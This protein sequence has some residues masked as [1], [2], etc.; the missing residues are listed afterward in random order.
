MSLS[1]T[2]PSVPS[3]SD[4]ARARAH[5]T[6]DA[7]DL[8]V[9]HEDTKG[10]ISARR[11]FIRSATFQPDRL[12]D[13]II[14]AGLAD[15]AFRGLIELDSEFYLVVSRPG[16]ASNPRFVLGLD[17]LPVDSLDRSGH[18]SGSLK[19]SYRNTSEWD[20]KNLPETLVA[21]GSVVSQDD[22]TDSGYHLFNDVFGEP[23]A[24]LRI[25][26]TR[27]HD[28]IGSR[29]RNLLLI[30]FGGFLLGSGYLI[31]TAI[32]RNVFK[33]IER[34][35]QSLAQIARD[36]QDVQTVP[37]SGSV[38]VGRL[39]TQVNEML[40]RLRQSESHL[41]RTERM[42]VAGE[43]SAGV[44]HNL[45]NILTGILGPAEFLEQ[46]LEDPVHLA[47]ARRIY[48]ASIRARDLVSRFGQAV[49]HGAPL[50]SRAVEVNDTVRTAIEA[51]RPRWQDESQREGVQI[52]IE[53][54]LRATLP[55][56]GTPDELHDII[57]SLVLNA[58]DALP[59]GGTVRIT[60]EE[61]SGNV[62]LRVSDDGIGMND[63][64]I[65]RV[66]EPFFT[67]KASIGSG[68]GLAAVHG[69]ATRWG[70]P[71]T[72]QVPSAV[73]PNSQ[74]NSQDRGKT[75]QVF[76]PGPYLPNPRIAGAES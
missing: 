7:V 31:T 54:D 73:D 29:T 12:I 38:D 32:R 2:H 56:Q 21:G 55:I 60:T 69:V 25:D 61:A 47:E 51:S 41:I 6:N 23:A 4:P 59:E 45:N 10:V 63:E 48:R 16:N 27:N 44:S 62:I 8:S 75:F 11:S 13:R 14:V 18:S 70:A 52:A 76:L 28:T 5:K 20:S 74:W 58:T 57:V 49:R 9:L 64:T 15:Q 34:L 39:E 36:G 19:L 71:C 72:Y 50:R 37:V 43:L 68:L 26:Y 35:S 3:P 53:T 42:R 40:D 22:G 17:R 1:P 24:I 67:T 30:L 33:P 65:K 46:N 66:F